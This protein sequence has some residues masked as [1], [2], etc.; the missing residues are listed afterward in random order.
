MTLSFPDLN[1]WLALNDPD[2][3]HSSDAWTWLNS[4]PS[5]HKLIFSRYTQV[6]LLLLLTNESVMGER[7]LTLGKAW[8]VY[9]RWLD[10]PGV[11]FY[12]EPRD[13]DTAFRETTA[14][15]AAKPASKAVGDCLLLA[16]A[17]ELRASLVTFD[18]AL[19]SLARRYGA[20]AIVPA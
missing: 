3:I 19:H 7:T 14:A 6:G 20:S 13:L 11:E 9:D 16:T 8:S 10:H 15:F 12:P 1:V 2:H 5:S 18:R 4:L 17:R